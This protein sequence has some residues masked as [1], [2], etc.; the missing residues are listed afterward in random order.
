MDEHEQEVMK[1][2][3]RRTSNGSSGVVKAILWN[4][5]RRSTWGAQLH[6][7]KLWRHLQITLEDTL[8]WN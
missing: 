5:R 4:S 1:I 8:F 2:L 7:R 6:M 3:S